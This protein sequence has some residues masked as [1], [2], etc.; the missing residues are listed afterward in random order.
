VDAAFVFEDEVC[1]AAVWETVSGC[2][3]KV[4]RRNES[5]N[6]HT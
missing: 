5:Q 4:K 2:G 3:A 6:P 1:M